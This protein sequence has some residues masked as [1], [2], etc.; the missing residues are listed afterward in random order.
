MPA[1]KSLQGA[2][3]GDQA[4]QQKAQT[5][6]HHD[7]IGVIGDERAGSAQVQ[8]GPRRGRLIAEGVDV[9][10]HVMAKAALV[11]GRYIQICVVQVRPHLDDGRLRDVEPQLAFRLGQCQPESAPQANAVTVAPEGLHRG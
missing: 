5:I 10:H 9:G 11:A 2:E 4:P 7:E 8:E 1:G 3:H 6:P